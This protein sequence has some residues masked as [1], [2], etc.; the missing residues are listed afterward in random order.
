MPEVFSITEFF[1]H[2]EMLDMKR[3]INFYFN[4]RFLVN[5]CVNSVFKLNHRTIL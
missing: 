4:S 1:N 3:C 5:N 2:R